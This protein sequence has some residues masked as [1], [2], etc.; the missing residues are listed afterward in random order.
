MRPYLEKTH[1]RKG[2]VEW[3]KVKPEFKSQCR[4][5]KNRGLQGKRGHQGVEREEGPL[6]AAGV[7]QGSRPPLTSDSVSPS[8][9]KQSHT[10]GTAAV[11]LGTSVPTLEEPRLVA[12]SHPQGRD[13]DPSGPGSERERGQR[14]VQRPCGSSTGF[15]IW[16]MTGFCGTVAPGG[17]K[18]NLRGSGPGPGWTTWP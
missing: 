9:G 2:L 7:T 8:P 3:L 12:T 6:G 18:K 4:K 5:I 1:H 14:Q 16:K 17:V 10:P 15:F 11:S 13:A